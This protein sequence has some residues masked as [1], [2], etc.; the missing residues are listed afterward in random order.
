MR[1]FWP[2]LLFVIIFVI[3]WTANHEAIEQQSANTPQRIISLAPSITET[4][5]ALDLADNIVAVTDYCDYPPAALSLPKV[6]G[7]VDANLEA[8]IG[9]RPDLVIVLAQQE[10]T[11]A[12]LKQLNI[13]TLVVRNTSL[14][15]IKQAMIQIGK[16]TGKTE[17]ALSLLAEM[18]NSIAIIDEKLRGLDRPNV[19][20]S[21]GHSLNNE[22]LNMIY[23]A[24]QH[25][26]Y[27][28]L[29]VLA[30]GHNVYQDQNLK[31]PSLSVEGV[32]QLNPQIIIDIFPDADDHNDDLN[33]IM[34]KWQA[35]PYIDAV[36]N[37]QVYIIEASYATIPGPRVVLLLKQFARFIHPEVD[38]NT[39]S[40]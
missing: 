1:R 33:I 12:Q 3:A 26:F 11:I 14:V 13:V 5:F 10:T 15:E 7:F 16:A 18:N 8:I 28:D 6:G 34:Q 9:L 29:I 37:K 40:L 38:W 24:G 4:L 30:G 22:Q 25:D 39:V 2:L 35:L 31:V 20:V 27:N 36:D 32:I 17:Q 23:I 19:L 21:I